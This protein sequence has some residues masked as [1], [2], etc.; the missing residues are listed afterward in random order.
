ME[1][2]KIILLKSVSIHSS[3]YKCTDYLQKSLSNWHMCFF[4]I[5]KTVKTNILFNYYDLVFT[6]ELAKAM[7]LSSDPEKKSKTR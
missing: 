4:V 7:I 6:P 2:Y 3:T 1:G 5:R